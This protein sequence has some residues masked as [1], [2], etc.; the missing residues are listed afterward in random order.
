MSTYL[1]ADLCILSVRVCIFRE[2]IFSDQV[3]ACLSIFPLVV[4]ACVRVMQ[5]IGCSLILRLGFGGK[6]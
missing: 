3:P 4:V 6:Y 2:A 5:L 1:G